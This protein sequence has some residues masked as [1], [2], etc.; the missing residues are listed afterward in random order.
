V[1]GNHDPTLA[2]VPNELGF[3]LLAEGTVV[4]GVALRHAPTGGGG[5]MQGALPDES[6]P[7]LCGH[8]HPVYTLRGPGDTLRLP[9][10]VISTRQ[11]ILP[12]FG[13]FTGGFKVEPTAETDL[14][15]AVQEDGGSERVA[16]FVSPVPGRGRR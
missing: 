14:Y 13:S 8:L 2:P 15:L 1:P 16:G 10:F 6:P 9:C 12:A 3:T 11:W 5:V 7:E 4:E